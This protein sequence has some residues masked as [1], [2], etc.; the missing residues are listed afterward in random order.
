MKNFLKVLSLSF[1]V[2][3]LCGC[4]REEKEKVVKCNLSNNDVVNG[5]ELKSEYTVFS[6]GDIVNKVETKEVVTSDKEEILSY[7][8]KTLNDTYDKYNS[9]YGGYTYDVTKNS[10]IVTS[11]VTIDYS[12]MD[13]DKFSKDNSSIKPAMTDDNKLTLDGIT[14]MY[15]SMGATC[16]E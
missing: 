2:M 13:L 7:F 11:N 3:I 12:K 8:E 10:N 4:G 14:S 9:E 1:I 5:Y 6:K 16:E 15:K